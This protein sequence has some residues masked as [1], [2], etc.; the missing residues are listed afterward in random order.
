M[1]QNTKSRPNILYACLEL[2]YTKETNE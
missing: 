2:K 1:T